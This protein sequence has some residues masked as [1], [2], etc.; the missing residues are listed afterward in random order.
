MEGDN[1]SPIVAAAH[2]WPHLHERPPGSLHIICGRRRTGKSTLLDDLLRINAQYDEVCVFEPS[3]PDREL[4]PSF[5]STEHIREDYDDAEVRKLMEHA[6]DAVKNGRNERRLLVIDDCALQT[7]RGELFRLCCSSRR[8]NVDV[9]IVVAHISGVLPSIRSNADY[10]FLM[11]TSSRED[12]QRY[13]R[14]FFGNI[15]CLFKTLDGLFDAHAGNH[16]A[17]VFE[18][19]SSSVFTYRARADHTNAGMPVVRGGGACFDPRARVAGSVHLIVG[20]RVTGKKT[21]LKHLLAEQQYR[22]VRV[23][24]CLWSDWDALSDVP[25]DTVDKYD[26]ADVASLLAEAIAAKRASRDERRA[27]VLCDCFCGNAKEMARQ[28]AL[29]QLCRSSRRC[30]VDVYVLVQ[31]LRAVAPLIRG[32]A[33]Y[34]FLM[35]ERQREAL[36]VAHREYFEHGYDTLDRFVE[37]VDQRT[38]DYG[39]VV[40]DRSSSGV[41]H[42]RVPVDK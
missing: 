33:D 36:R 2:E 35:R 31:D 9:Y 39:V 20:A 28:E 18:R 32:N 22:D 19:Q 11:P 13:H 15:G 27:L 5:I 42:Y 26:D 23:V 24:A 30:N 6:I 40:F 12:R 25:S 8:W 38:R 29:F 3:L 10:V 1:T 4:L 17:V 21:L 41:Q 7:P 37:M 34:V 14:E 16:G